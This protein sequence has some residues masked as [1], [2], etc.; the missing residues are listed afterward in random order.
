MIILIAGSTHTGKTALA[1][2]LI[3]KYHYPSMSLDHLKMGLIR[4]GLTNLTPYDDDKMT[5]L[6]WPIVKEMIKTVIENDQNMIIEGCYFPYDWKNHFEQ[7]YVKNIKYV[8]L[9]M[10]SKYIEEHFEDIKKY[11]SVIENRGEDSSIDKDVLLRDNKVSLEMCKK[12]GCDYLL[13][14]DEYGVDI[15]IEDR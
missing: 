9:V 1:Q 5:D 11:A 14:D 15:H 6:L 8:C 2:N 4:S 10:S 12:Y 3:E 7:E 13:I